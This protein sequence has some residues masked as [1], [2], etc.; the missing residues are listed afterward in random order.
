MPCSW[1]KLKACFSARGG[2]YIFQYS[3]TA[4]NEFN[5][6]IIV[7]CPICH[8]PRP[9]LSLY[10]VTL[11]ENALQCTHCNQRHKLKVLTLKPSSC[12]FVSL[13]ELCIEWHIEDSFPVSSDF[14]CLNET[15]SEE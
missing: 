5:V 15:H 13:I 7:A 4:T 10:K 6:N 11:M 3:E 9:A 8:R 12:D 14:V 2:H 1:A